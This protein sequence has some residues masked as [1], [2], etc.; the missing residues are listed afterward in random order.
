MRR[1]R[2][3][4]LGLVIA[5]LAHSAER[6]TFALGKD[7]FLLDG[8]TFQVISGEMHPARIPA[9]YWRHRVRMAKAMGVNTIHF[10]LPKPKKLGLEWEAAMFAFLT[11]EELDVM[12]RSTIAAL[13]G[14]QSAYERIRAEIERRA[15]R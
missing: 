14:A 11:D 3:A 7:D 4:A 6:H 9:E 2:L 13:V 8:R 5:A 1:L 15:R 12:L 10:A